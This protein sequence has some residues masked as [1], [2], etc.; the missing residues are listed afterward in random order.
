MST[1]LQNCYRIVTVKVQFKMNFQ[2]KM[3]CQTLLRLYYIKARR[4]G[5]RFNVESRATCRRAVPCADRL[6]WPLVAIR[7][8]SLGHQLC[9]YVPRVPPCLDGVRRCPP[10]GDPIVTVPPCLDDTP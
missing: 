4:S 8:R 5:Q 9:P 1:R 2:F 3:N 10:C 6:A 7:C